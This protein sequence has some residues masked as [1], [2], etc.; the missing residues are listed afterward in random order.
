MFL[1][2]LLVFVFGLVVGSFLNVVIYRSVKGESPF[3]GRSA[4][5]NCGKKIDW[6]HNIPLLSF[7][8]VRGRCQ[9]CHKKISWQ[10]PVVEFM[11]GLLFIW[12]VLIG[13][14]FFLLA[15][16]PFD[17]WQ[18]AFWLM[19]GVVLLAVVVFDLVYGIIPDGLNIFL[20]A[21][22]L[23]YRLALSY[24]GLMRPVDLGLALIS[25]GALALFFAALYYGTRG[26]GFGFGDVKLAPALGLLL[27]WPKTLVGA[28]SA[29]FIGAVVAVTLLL[30]RR[31]RFGQTIPFGPFLVLGTV[32]ALL[33]GNQIWSWY[34][35]L[36]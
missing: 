34:M 5:D 19:V 27:G 7:F 14:S 30:M 31:K 20:F 13:R 4:C 1:L 6:R 22:A 10:Y 26:K 36:L 24:F 35:G 12:W 16:H 15:A 2:A 23:I 29:F 9:N 11:V 3:A 8:W 28:M 33:W 17:Y 18:P 32:V 25:G 21:W